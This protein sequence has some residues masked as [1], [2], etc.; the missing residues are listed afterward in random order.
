MIHRNRLQK[1]IWHW[2][3]NCV[4]LL[5]AGTIVFD[6]KM[7]WIFESRER[8]IN[9]ER[10]LCLGASKKTAWTISQSDFRLYFEKLPFNTSSLTLFRLSIVGVWDFVLLFKNQISSGKSGDN[11]KVEINNK[12]ILRISSELIFC[13]MIGLVSVCKMLGKMSIYLLVEFREVLF[14]ERYRVSR[15]NNEATVNNQ[16]RCRYD[17]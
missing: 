13:N 9:A 5:A 16:Y 3:L 14:R 11:P 15:F 10:I 2:H 8:F 6:R 17:M 12:T 4:A 7:F 1:S